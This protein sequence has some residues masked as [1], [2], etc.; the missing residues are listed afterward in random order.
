MF[1]ACILLT[2]AIA[3]GTLLTFLYQGQSTIAL[4]LCVGACSGLALMATFGFLISGFLGL[5][6]ASISLSAALLLLPAL[7][8]LRTQCREQLSQEARAGAQHIRDSSFL[9]LV[10]LYAGLA[11]VLGLAFAQNIREQPDGIYTGVQNN[12]GDL[13]FHLQVISSFVYGQNIPVEDPT[14]AGVRFTYPILADFLS[15]MLVRTGASIAAAMWLQSMVLALAFIGLL[16][17]WTR[18]LTGNRLAAAF[19]PLLVIFSGGLGWWLLMQDLRVSDGGLLHLLA[20]LPRD[21]TIVNGTIFRWGN[22]LT[23]LLLPQRS[24]LFGL[25]LAVCVFYQWWAAIQSPADIKGPGKNETSPTKK[26]LANDSAIR[27]M[28]AAGICAGLLPLIHT[29]GFLVVFGAAVCLA[30]LFRL[31]WRA[32]M[33]FFAAALLIALPEILWLSHDSAIHAGQFIGWQIGWDRGGYNALWFWFVNT[34]F[35]IPLLLAALLSRKS[36][37]SVSQ[38]LAMF[39]APFSLCFIIPNFLK[40]S[41]WIWDNIKFLFYW[42]VASVPLVAFVLARLW[43]QGS[44]RRWLAG[45]LLASLTL[46]GALDILRVITHAAEFQEFTPQGIQIAKLIDVLVPPRARV[47]HAP[48]WNSPIFLTGRRSLLGY[49]GWIWSRGLETSQREADIHKM[50]S[51]GPAALALF[52]N[53]RVDYALI[54]PSQLALHVNQ[55]FWAG[56]TRLAQVGAYQL[57]KTDCK[58]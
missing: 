44:R 53:Y 33:V 38:R 54:G 1:F 5:T 23:T 20:N 43:Q 36:E 45:G 18:S 52:Q 51:G 56:C 11:L 17:H 14:Y 40:L 10:V 42:Y 13:P 4:R 37:Y 12:L 6:T 31:L 47:L 16:H 46:S 8:L 50:Y 32:W 49:P 30:L 15:A 21:Y 27:R 2:I 3:G 34:G 29:H 25:P 9:W 48:D 35:F 26:S 55:T 28:L 22:S 24:F 7:L 41:P 19:A 39:Y 57:Y 58:P